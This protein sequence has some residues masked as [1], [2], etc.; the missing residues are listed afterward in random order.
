[1][2]LLVLEDIVPGI[3]PSLVLTLNIR[4]SNILALLYKI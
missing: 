2:A 3:Q 1:M 4:C